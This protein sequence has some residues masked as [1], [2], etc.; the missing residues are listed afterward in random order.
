[1]SILRPACYKK[2]SSLI[3]SIYDRFE[4]GTGAPKQR[5]TT[6]P[7][8]ETFIKQIIITTIGGRSAAGLEIDTDLFTFGI[9]SLT[10]T[11]IR[12]EI[13]KGLE[14]GEDVKLGQNVVYE[15]PSITDLAKFLLDTQAGGE[16]GRGDEGIHGLMVEMVQKFSVQ[17]KDAPRGKPGERKGGAVVVLTGATGSLGAHILDQLIR[18]DGVT[19]VICLSRASSHSDSMRRIQDSLSLRQRTLSQS[20]MS[21]ITSLAADVNLPNLGLDLHELNDLKA[22]ITHII[23]N[24]WPVNFNLSLNS[25]EPHIQ[26]AVNL[27]KLALASDN[28]ASF[29]F[30]SS[31]G[32]VQGRPNP[33]IKEVFSDSPATAGGMGYARSKWVMEGILERCIGI[34]VGVL[35]IGQLVGD[36]EWYVLVSWLHGC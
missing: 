27:L 22:N 18:R 1:M 8:L 9:D 10:A 26:G 5:L 20:A 17:V 23:H 13:S 4:C 28:T 35:R 32:T 2:F 30:S 6:L 29:H 16:E 14:M 19:R 24:A 15:H 36:T 7:S 25:F 3:T 33:L 34:R 21:K 12:N 31:V 11:R